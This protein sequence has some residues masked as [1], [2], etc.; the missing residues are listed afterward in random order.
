MHNRDR[1]AAR[2]GNVLRPD[3]LS[4]AVTALFDPPGDRLD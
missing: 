4:F 3:E 2:S 1:H